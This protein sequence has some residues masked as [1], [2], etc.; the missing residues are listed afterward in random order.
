[1]TDSSDVCPV[2][3]VEPVSGPEAALV[4]D[5]VVEAVLDEELDVAASE[6]VTVSVTVVVTPGVWE[7]VVVAVLGA[8]SED[9]LCQDLGVVDSG[10]DSELEDG[11]FA[12]ELSV[13]PPSGRSA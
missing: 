3:A 4:V 12:E 5:D 1:M 11:S 7:V 6:G 8:F 13:S 10:L 9:E 2:V